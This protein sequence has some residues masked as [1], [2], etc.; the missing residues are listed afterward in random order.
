[1]ITRSNAIKAAV[2][3]LFAA[4]AAA[5]AVSFA[6]YPARCVAELDRHSVFAGDSITYSVNVLSKS[7]LQA[8][9]Q[10]ASAALSQFRITDSGA[11]REDFLGRTRLTAWYALAQYT[12]GAYVIPAA[13]ATYRASDGFTRTLESE[14]VKIVVK[15]A[16]GKDGRSLAG[17]DIVSDIASVKERPRNYETREYARRKASAP[18]LIK[19]VGAPGPISLVNLTDIMFFGAEAVLLL[20]AA[21]WVVSIALRRLGRALEVP[22]YESARAQLD[23]AAALVSADNLR[24]RECCAKIS[25]ALRAYVEKEFGTRSTGLTT[26]EFLKVIA[27]VAGANE[28]LQQAARS[29]FALC[30]LAKFSGCEPSAEELDA[31]M[32]DA[33]TVLETLHARKKESLPKP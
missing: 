10:D 1:M 4:L 21:G 17:V 27:S 15:S 2:I 30:D 20:L 19:I 3:T 24:A 33:F 12:P 7:G 5:Q 18:V 16:L 28:K 26:T 25:A 29:V 32:R 11:A 13:R 31:C 22:P 23:A 8:E 6:L 14:P 9:I